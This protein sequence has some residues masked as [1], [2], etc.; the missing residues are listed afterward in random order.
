M[1]AATEAR[2]LQ[3]LDKQDITDCLVRYC[4]AMDRFDKDL[5]LSCYH[6]D[7]IDDHGA[8]VGSPIEFWN[9]HH[10]WHAKYNRGHHHAISNIT[11]ELKGDTAHSE[12]YWLFESMNSDGSNS[13]SGGRYIDRLEKRNGEWKI[14][15]RAC[16]IEWNGTLG[17]MTLPESFVKAYAETGTSSR[18]RNDPSYKRPLKI[19]R[20]AKA[21]PF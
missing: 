10:A 9:Y 12:T 7:A 16:L 13:L 8:F 5:L 3:M 1:D 6:P 2:L 11:I 15:A 17:E 18:D 4:R 21:D 14:A 20:P 19:A